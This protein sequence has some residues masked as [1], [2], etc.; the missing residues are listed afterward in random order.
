MGTRGGHLT[1]GIRVKSSMNLK[2]LLD[3]LERLS[4]LPTPEVS[5]R[6]R[7]VL[8]DAFMESQK[9][10]HV[11]SGALIASGETSTSEHGSEW[12]GRI[13]YGRGG[14]YY[15]GWEFARGEGDD[16][17]NPFDHLGEYEERFEDVIDG[18]IRDA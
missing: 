1:G 13:T 11:D 2:P 5:A 6:L 14:V 4:N 16:S 10:V 15:A 17:H 18:V 9:H 7:G 12:R 3:E 8:D